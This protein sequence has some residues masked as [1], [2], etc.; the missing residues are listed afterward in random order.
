L[1]VPELARQNQDITSVAISSNGQVIIA[2][3]N[4]GKIRVWQTEQSS[5]EPQKT[6]NFPD[7]SSSPITSIAI[8]YDGSAVVSSNEDGIA[9]LWTTKDSTNYSNASKLSS[10]SIGV[11]SISSDGKTV[12]SGGADGVVRVLKMEGRDDDRK[13]KG[14]AE[15]INSIVLVDNRTIISGSDDGTIGLWR[16]LPSGQDRRL[17]LRGHSKKVNTIAIS[18]N[19]KVAISSGDDN[20][21]RFWDIA[22][23]LD[24]K[25]LPR[26][27]RKLISYACERLKNHTI[28]RQ[29]D[30]PEIKSIK[31]ICSL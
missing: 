23:D 11:V 18:P 14:H 24:I 25:R 26:D 19:K 16:I 6:L 21:I 9:S 1:A 3:G 20:T 8:N 30:K 27:S 28:L 12:V 5:E 4:D 15:N 2:G 17:I 13:L 10:Q 29:V 22:M 31:A 7:N